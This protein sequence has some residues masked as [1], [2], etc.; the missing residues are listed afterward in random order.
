M[1]GTDAELLAK[2]IER[3]M[4]TMRDDIAGIRDDVAR[5][6]EQV[7]TLAAEHGPRVAVLEHRVGE[8]ESDLKALRDEEVRKGSQLWML[9]VSV[10]GSFLAA[11]L[12]IGSR[13]ITGG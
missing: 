8:V 9:K 7:Q 12:S 10:A 4:G 1:P 5:V 2:V 6:A 13:F 11:F 3:E